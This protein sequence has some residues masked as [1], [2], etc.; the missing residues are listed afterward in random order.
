MLLLLPLVGT[1]FAQSQHDAS[2]G[3]LEPWVDSAIPLTSDAL[4]GLARQTLIVP[5][6]REGVA[7]TYAGVP[8]SVL[9]E[10]AG[11]PA[12]RALRGNRLAIV[13]IAEASDG[14]KVAF[15]IGELDASVGDA[16][17]LVADSLNGAPLD[18]KHG[19]LQLIAPMDKR[20][21]RWV[22][23]VVRLR[24]LDASHVK[25]AK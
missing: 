8:I 19:P 9:L 15:S 18:A 7:G 2:L 5:A 17:V 11:V 14:Y 20:G 3:T 6:G 22:R 24:V 25:D 4:R 16:Q 12:G 23:G 13:V 1:A 21:A 10:Q